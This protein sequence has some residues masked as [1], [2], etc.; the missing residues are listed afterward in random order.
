MDQAKA[1]QDQ[2]KWDNAIGLYSKVADLN[3]PFKEQALQA[4]PIVKQLETGADIS[5]IEQQTYQTAMSALG[6]NQYTQARSLFQHVIDLKVPDSALA[7]KAQAQ[8]VDLDQK[9]KAQEEFDAA[10]RATSRNDLDGALAQFSRIAEGGGP[11]AARAKARI[12]ELLRVKTEAAANAALNQKF[13]AAVEA[14]NSNDLSGA[15]DKFKAISG[16]G[17]TFGSEAQPPPTTHQPPRPSSTCASRSAHG[18]SHASAWTCTVTVFACRHD[19]VPRPTGFRPRLS[20]RATKPIR[21]WW[22]RC[23]FEKGSMGVDPRSST[24]TPSGITSARR[25]TPP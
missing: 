1:A 4:I 6:K 7:P 25:Q 14:E 3:G 17:G 15:L 24:S 22:V 20:V 18:E 16:K 23:L 13:D 19:A 10:V 8:L 21:A 9:L 2:K 5:K 12:P 11:F